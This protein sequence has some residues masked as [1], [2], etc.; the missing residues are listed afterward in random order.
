MDGLACLVPIT[1]V[2]AGSYAAFTNI[3]VLRVVNVLVLAALDAVDD[4]RLEIDQDCSWDISSVVTLVEEDI[5][6]VA[7]FSG[8]VLEIA[9]LVNAV[10]LA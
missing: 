6:P 9:I 8:K 5:L 4:T 2:V 1:P 10:L 3:E 7:S